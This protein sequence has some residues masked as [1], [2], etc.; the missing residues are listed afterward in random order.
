MKVKVGCLIYLFLLEKRI[1]YVFVLKKLSPFKFASFLDLIWCFCNGGF[2][3]FHITR[4]EI[5]RSSAKT[6]NE[7]SHHEITYLIPSTRRMNNVVLNTYLHRPLWDTISNLIYLA[8]KYFIC[9]WKVRV[10]ENLSNYLQNL[11]ILTT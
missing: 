4:S 7:N 3:E 5:F 9:K 6:F 10:N 2:C 8:L 11:E 1:Q